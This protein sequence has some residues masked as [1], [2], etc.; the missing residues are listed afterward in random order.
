M[1]R[2]DVG[3]IRNIWEQERVEICEHKM[4]A[5]ESKICIE[6]TLFAGPRVRPP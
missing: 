3:K 4:L 6:L 5:K 1:A 2:L